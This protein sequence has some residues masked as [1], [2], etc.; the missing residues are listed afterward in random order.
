MPGYIPPEYHLKSPEHLARNDSDLVESLKSHHLPACKIRPTPDFGRDAL[1]PG[2][3]F[4][5]ALGE[6]KSSLQRS[7]NH[8]CQETS[9]DLT[10]GS[11][12]SGTPKSTA[13]LLIT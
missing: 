5:H 8:V 11:I 12:N 7:S 6:K 3:F 9:D 4:M 10:F 13:F 1:L 2:Q